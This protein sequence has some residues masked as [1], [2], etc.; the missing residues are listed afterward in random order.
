[1]K[2]SAVTADPHKRRVFIAEDNPILLQGLH[3]ALTAYGYRVRTA[4]DG[5]AMMRLLE[6]AGS[7]PPE[8]L[9]LDVMMPE[10]TGLEVL[11][12]LRADA[13]W[14]RLPVVLLTAATQDVISATAAADD[15]V[16]LLVKP[17]RLRDLLDTVADQM[18]PAP[19]SPQNP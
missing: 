6:A 9:L 2:S 15:L 3:R 8:L 7:A 14:A 11:E 10:L 4:S 1:M 12:R 13:A 19:V 17:F 5:A 18:P 16:S